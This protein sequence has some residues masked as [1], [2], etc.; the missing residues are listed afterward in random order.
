[1]KEQRILWP[2]VANSKV[3]TELD[4]VG[5]QK[6]VEDKGYFKDF[7]FAAAST[8][9]PLL[10]LVCEGQTSQRNLYGSAP[11]RQ[12]PQTALSEVK[13]SSSNFSVR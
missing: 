12:T 11:A 4:G 2:R 5:M 7:R 10:A 9:S 3:A 13:S 1:M 6:L 8:P